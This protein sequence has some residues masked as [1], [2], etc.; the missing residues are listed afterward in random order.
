MFGLIM[1]VVIKES[2]KILKKQKYTNLTFAC[3][4]VWPRVMKARVTVA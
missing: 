1:T 2:K 4:I 3:E